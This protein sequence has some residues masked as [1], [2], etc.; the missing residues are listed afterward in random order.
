MWNCSGVKS[1]VSRAGGNDVE[2]PVDVIPCDHAVYSTYKIKRIQKKL[3]YYL[4]E[5]FC[6]R[7]NDFVSKWRCV[8]CYKN[9]E[10]EFTGKFDFAIIKT[11]Y[12][13]NMRDLNR[14]RR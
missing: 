6:S 8:K 2:E 14:K 1:V 13:R 10:V 9:D 3:H 11:S 7:F 12:S 5:I 4:N